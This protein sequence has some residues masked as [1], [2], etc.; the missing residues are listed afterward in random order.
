MKTMKITNEC[1]EKTEKIL[2]E[3]QSLAM[4]LNVRGTP[5]FII[6]KTPI[7][8]ADILLI[9]NLLEKTNQK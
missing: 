9:K 8:G 3:H 6:D 1:K 2:A 5:F 4:K 7:A